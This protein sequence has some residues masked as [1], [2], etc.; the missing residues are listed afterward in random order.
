[1]NNEA[2]IIFTEK[3]KP[4]P[5]HS[6]KLE[7]FLRNFITSTNGFY[8]DDNLSKGIISQYFKLNN[9]ICIEQNVKIQK[10]D[11]LCYTNL[12]YHINPDD[13]KVF[14]QT[15]QIIN[16]INTQIDYGSF[17]IDEKTGDIRYRTYYKPD[18]V[19]D[20]ESLDKMLG[21]PMYVINRYGHLFIEKV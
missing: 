18:S 15:L 11:Y 7:W 14:L 10:E 2:P 17:E 21:Y 1:M 3:R 19:V 5:K 4:E 13:K 16:K 9:G 20:F 12:S 6:K 8:Y